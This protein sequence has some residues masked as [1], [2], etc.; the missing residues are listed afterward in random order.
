MKNQMFLKVKNGKVA[1]PQKLRVTSMDWIAGEKPSK[2][3]LA[4]TGH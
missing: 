2:S 1:L 4:W 3:G